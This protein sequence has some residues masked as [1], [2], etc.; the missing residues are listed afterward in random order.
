[1]SE[2]A[3]SR[4]YVVGAYAASPAHRQWIPDREERYLQELAA[5]R[6]VA[7]F[8][9]PWMGS[10]HPH[11]DEWLLNCLPD[12][13][14]AVITDIP[15]IMPRLHESDGFGLASRDESSRQRAIDGVSRMR[16]DVLRLN[17]RRGHGVVRAVELHSAPRR[18][19]AN[20]TALEAS[21]VEIASWDWDGAELL[22]EHCDA[23]IDGQESEKG[24][25][26]L[27]EE[28]AAIRRAGADIGL[29][30]NWGRSAIELRNA[31]GVAD[32]VAEAAGSG[33]LR[34]LMLSGASDR[35]GVLGPAWLDAHHPFRQD[36]RHPFGDPGSLLTEGRAAASIDAAGD[37]DWIGVKLSWAGDDEAGSE[38]VLMI[39]QA[40]D[41]VAE[42]QA[43]DVRPASVATS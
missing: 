31:D 36:L 16:E 42:L 25:L 10:L 32:Q 30:I 18:E 26:R 35:D 23:Q 41:A 5:L 39:E 15:F 43:T 1:M 37:V 8:E 20:V 27:D 19:R 9:L 2:S 24:F 11:D 33:L 40:L 3:P 14:G 29:T 22:L 7:A 34:G 38:R 17:D 13:V 28:I 12:G 6:S 4:R 21:L